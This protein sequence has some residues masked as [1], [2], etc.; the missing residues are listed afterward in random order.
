MTDQ[1]I[2]LAFQSKDVNR[3]NVMGDRSGVRA[4]MFELN[5]RETK[6]NLLWKRT[7]T[8]RIA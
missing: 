5:K 8:V 3:E 6:D 1:T 2:K 7:F 4:E